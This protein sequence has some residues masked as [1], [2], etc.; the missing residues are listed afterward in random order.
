MPSPE[1]HGV[2]L[3]ARTGSAVAWRKVARRGDAGEER[4]RRRGNFPT[5]C[6][7]FPTFVRPVAPCR[8]VRPGRAVPTSL[9]PSPPRPSSRSAVP[10]RAVPGRGVTGRWPSPRSPDP[11]R[12]AKAGGGSPPFP[13]PRRSGHF[14]LG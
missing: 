10:G 13:P 7:F 3:V 2:A 5:H 14:R 11:G 12:R 4:R 1:G 9:R 8:P 6:A